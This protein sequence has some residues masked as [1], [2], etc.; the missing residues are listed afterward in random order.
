MDVLKPTAKGSLYWVLAIVVL[1]VASLL[2]AFAEQVRTREEEVYLDFAGRQRMLSERLV[3]QAIAPETKRHA[4]QATADLLFIT[5]NAMIDGGRVP[6]L[7]TGGSVTTVHPWPDPSVAAALAEHRTALARLVGSIGRYREALS[8]RSGAGVQDV[9]ERGADAVTTADR[10]VKL[11]RAGAQTRRRWRLAGIACV[12]ALFVVMGGGLWFHF[13]TNAK[14]LDNLV[15][16]RTHELAEVVDQLKTAYSA[17]RKKH[18]EMFQFVEQMPLGVYI[19]DGKGRPVFVNEQAKVLLGPRYLEA[20][21]A[22]ERCTFI[23]RGSDTP[24]PSDRLPTTLAL[25]GQVVE[26]DDIDAQL[27]GARVQ[28]SIRAAPIRDEQGRIK[29]ALAAMQDIS[30]RIRAETERL[31]GQKLQSVGQLAAGVAHEINTPMQYIGDNAHFINTALERL[32]E[33][34]GFHDQLMEQDLDPSDYRAKA[35]A[36]AKALRLGF[37]Q[38]RV[39]SALKSTI[40]GVA[41]VSTIVSAMKEFSHPGSEEKTPTDIN[42]AIE[43]TMTVSR[44]E[45]KYLAELETDLCA[46]LPLVPCVPGEFNQVLLNMIVNSAHAIEERVAVDG[47]KDGK[48][49]ISTKSDDRFAIITIADNGC[50]IAP[51]FLDKVFDPFFTTKEVGKGT[52]QGLAIARAIVVGK[53]EG[54][55]NV[56][57]APGQGTTLTI[58]LPLAAAVE[59]EVA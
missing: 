39:P 25:Q 5:V 31:Q 36:K 43:T 22:S 12:L 27:P 42:R 10:V 33:M 29:Y 7:V 26:V 44:N 50:G 56:E 2:L 51:R 21:A 14:R 40:E 4:F 1:I 17:I 45:W 47:I 24:Y 46:G 37:L 52:G 38:K 9:L 58:R 15:Q 59:A 19:L 16:A 32:L 53:H 48:I 57:S 13:R 11:L 28:L 18:S 6:A 34:I 54:T 55:L 3:R 30:D 35:K 23:V 49:Q 8:R 41:A 20:A